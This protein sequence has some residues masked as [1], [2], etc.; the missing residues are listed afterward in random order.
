[1]ET[2]IRNFFQD[3]NK[4]SKLVSNILMIPLLAPLVML[5]VG[6][7]LQFVFYILMFVPGILG[8]FIGLFYIESNKISLKK[9]ISDKKNLPIIFLVLF[10]LVTFISC[11]FAKD[12][13]LAFIGDRYRREGFITYLGYAGYFILGMF[14]K[15]N[16]KQANILI[17]VSIVLGTVALIS[18]VQD[19]TLAITSSFF[20]ANHYG[21]YLV[22]TTILSLILFMNGTNYQSKIFYLISYVLNLVVLIYNNTFGSFLG[23]LAGLII[24]LV[25]YLKKSKK[26]II[27]PWIVI[28]LLSLLCQK[29]GE[30]IVWNNF[31]ILN[32]DAKH[33]ISNL[34]LQNLTYEDKQIGSFRGELWHTTP[35]FIAEKP[36][37]GYGLDNSVSEYSR[38]NSYVSDRPH[39][40]FLYI[41]ASSGFIGAMLYF[42]GYFM[43]LLKPFIKIIKNKKI[44][45]EEEILFFII[46]AFFVS[47]LFGNTMFYTSPYIIL[48]LGMLFRK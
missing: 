19:S 39:N 24:A 48:F 5:L 35:K 30:N 43:I 27:I 31:R 11:L 40:I 22:I 38:Y 33:A 2:A 8:L 25:Y 4:I 36:L 47:S 46:G 17:L 26:L 13:T 32:S 6:N 16:S 3:K 9:I 20:N 7:K 28:I 42:T 21:Y 10:L 23:V 15:K 14:N 45:K 37:I 18:Y 1:M 41:T 44:T 12:K 29:S 34:K